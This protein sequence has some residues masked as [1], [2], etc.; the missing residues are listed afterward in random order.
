MKWIVIDLQGRVLAKFM[1]E[2]EAHDFADSQINYVYVEEENH[3]L[4]Q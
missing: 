2:S 4:Q 1:T 3:E